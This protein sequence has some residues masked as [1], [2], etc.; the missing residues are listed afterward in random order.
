MTTEQELQNEI[1]AMWGDLR[2]SGDMVIDAPSRKVGMPWAI[3]Y[4]GV[5]FPVEIDGE[6]VLVSIPADQAERFARAVIALV[7][8]AIEMDR[9]CDAEIAVH[10]A[11]SKAKGK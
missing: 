4:E 8:E 10:D 6:F 7:P 1:T 2:S 9:E 3:P 11:I 5:C